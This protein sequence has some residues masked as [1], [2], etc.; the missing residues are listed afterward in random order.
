MLETMTKERRRTI[1]R[2]LVNR[3]GRGEHLRIEQL[4]DHLRQEVDH[5][6]EEQPELSEYQLYDLTFSFGENGLVLQ[7]E[8]RR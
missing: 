7:M 1:T 4:M 3:Y 8:F 2:L 6:R 5:V